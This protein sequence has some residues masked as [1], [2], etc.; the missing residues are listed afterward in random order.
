MLFLGLLLIGIAG[1]CIA[2]KL[3]LK[4]QHV[5]STSSEW[6]LVLV[7]Q[8][9]PIPKNYEV[10]L[11]ELSNGKQV[12]ERIYPELQEMFDAARANGIYPVVGEG[13]RTEQEQRNMMEE[14]ILAYQNEGY[15]KKEAK[16]LAEE[17]VA[18]PGK[19][20]HQLGLAVDING[21]SLQ[22]TN[23]TVYAWLAENAWQYGFVLR[24]PAD[25]TDLTGIEYEPWHYRYVGKEAA[26][27]MVSQKFCLEEY[28]EQL[29]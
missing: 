6:N 24:Y 11:L 14:K 19:S 29:D 16:A 3:H 12:D 7:N 27:E 23:D 13:Y 20:E 4:L 2:G 22:S 26:R 9:N 15:S 1:W 8:W 17:V 28:L 21:D 25:K 18:D 10:N 5:Q